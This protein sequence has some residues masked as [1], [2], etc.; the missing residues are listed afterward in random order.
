MKRVLIAGTAVAL[1]DGSVLGVSM[2]MGWAPVAVVA[3]VAGLVG[4]VLVALATPPPR[5]AAAPTVTLG[6][7]LREATV[8]SP[9]VVEP[10][11]AQP[12]SAQSQPEPD[13]APAPVGK[14]PVPVAA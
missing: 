8:D 3:A 13:P 10:A 7:P 6:L 4:A 11:E 14:T 5:A 2:A 1:G 9:D 12:S